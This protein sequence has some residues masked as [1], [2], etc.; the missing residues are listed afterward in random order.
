MIGAIKHKG[1]EALY[2]QDETKGVKQSLVKRLRY[3]LALLNT[4]SSIEDMN[5]PPYGCTSF[6]GIW[7]DIMPCPS[8]VTGGS[9]SALKM[10]RPKMLT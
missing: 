9:F 4:A 5:L 7:P 10:D 1:L 3:I 8:P 2:Y 6:G